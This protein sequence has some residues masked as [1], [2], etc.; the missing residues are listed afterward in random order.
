MVQPGR[1]LGQRHQ[2]EAAS[3]HARVRNFNLRGA[4]NA[5]A[6]EKDIKVDDAGATRRQS[7][8][9]ERALDFLQRVEQLARQEQCLSLEDAVYKPRLRVKINRFGFIERRP[10]K[11]M[12][13]CFGQGRD[14]ALDVHDAVAE[15]RSEGQIDLFAFEHI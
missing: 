5:R 2:N 13:T 6:E 10:A 1:E 3:G 9:P 12:H 4:N 8:A 7:S 14:G 11:N 15:I